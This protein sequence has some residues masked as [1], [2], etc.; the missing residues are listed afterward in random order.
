MARG[1][2][3]AQLF[4]LLF[5]GL[6]SRP[7]DQE[8]TFEDHDEENLGIG[9]PLPFVHGPA[10]VGSLSPA[11][12]FFSGSVPPGSAREYFLF[13]RSDSSICCSSFSYLF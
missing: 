6:A 12:K 2:F 13:A 11:R 4:S 7:S 1:R 8:G 9:W 5:L 3:L 10:F